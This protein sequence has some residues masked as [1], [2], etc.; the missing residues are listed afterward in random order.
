MKL[1]I[2]G[3]NLGSHMYVS[4]Q[5]TNLKCETKSRLNNKLIYI[6]DEQ[7]CRRTNYYGNIRIRIGE[8][9]IG[10]YGIGEN[11]IGEHGIGKNGIGEHG[12]G[13]HGIGEYGI[14]EHGIGEHGIGEHEIGEYGIGEMLRH[15]IYRTVGF[16]TS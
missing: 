16:A 9:G 15:R 14:G 6:D 11:G 12:I 8:L 4:K 13:E 5:I 10:E 3:K 1:L 2:L 7:V